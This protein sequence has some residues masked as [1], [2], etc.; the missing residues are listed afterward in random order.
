[1]KLARPR[2]RRCAWRVNSLAQRAT[3]TRVE[4]RDHDLPLGHQHALGLAQHLVRVVG[5]LEHVRQH[6]QVDALRGERQLQRVGGERRAG[7]Q[8]ERKRY[9]MRFW[10]RKSTSGRPI[11]TARK[12]N[13]SSTALSNCASSHSR[14]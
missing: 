5:E 1:M 11:C 2:A 13:M 3:A 10:R 6:D 8:R 7:L 4:A 9:G 12:P 14:T